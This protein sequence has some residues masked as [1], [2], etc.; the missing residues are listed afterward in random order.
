MS[1]L[2]V[3]SLNVDQISYCDRLPAPGETLIGSNY[4]TGLGGK[5]ANQAVQAALLSEP[6]KVV[7]LGAVGD[8]SNGKWYLENLA[9]SGVNCDNILV[10]NDIST[11]VAPITVAI[12]SGENSIVVI[13]GANLKLTPADL[14]ENL[15]LF[16]NAK[17]VICQNEISHESTKKALRMGRENGCLTIYSPA[18]CPKRE[19]FE[20][21]A[22]LVDFC[23]PNQT[24]ASEL[25]GSQDLDEST[26]QIQKLGVKNVV[27]TLGGSG[28][29]I[30]RAG[31]ARV[32][33]FPLA[34]DV[35]VV[36]TTGAG[37]SFSGAFAHSLMKSPQS[38]IYTHAK[39]ASIVA[40]LSVTK[41]G[42]QKSYHNYNDIKKFI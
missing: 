17:I 31:S 41:K 19:H 4:E 8:D 32:E 2:V 9:K 5:G 22:N 7:M 24:E 40:S 30:L 35:K 42:T 10:K 13:P 3:G 36:D 15:S 1:I 29:G 28:Y 20:E 26:R 38:E 37:D 14:E 18:P 11:G 23:V 33:K 16:K 21:F 27:V 34:Q 12:S 39:F 6:G 25:G